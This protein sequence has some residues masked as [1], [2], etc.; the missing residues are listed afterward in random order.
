MLFK[1]AAMI[2]HDTGIKFDFINL[3]GGFGIPYKPEQA[4]I[5]LDVVSAGIHGAYKEYIE[6]TGIGA[7]ASGHRMRQGHNGAARFTWYR[8]SGTCPRKYKDYVGLDACMANLMR[9]ALYGAYHHITVLGKENM[10][11]DHVYDVVGS[12]CENNDKFAVNRP[13]PEI[14]PGDVFVLHSAGAHGYA[15]GFQYNGKL[16]CA[17]LLVTPGGKVRQIRRAE[18]LDDYLGTIESW[19]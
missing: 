16:R 10:P 13:L 2:N 12:L 14:V 4:A 6:N 18:V 15:M 17:E 11:K 1:L 5:D 9:P 7:C 8:R 19:P 3:G